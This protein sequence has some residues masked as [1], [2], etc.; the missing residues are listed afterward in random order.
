MARRGRGLARRRRRAG[1]R[2]ARSRRP[3]RDSA[4]S[5]AA[6]RPSRSPARARA[7]A[8]RR[9]ARE[10]P[11]AV[12]P[13]VAVAFVAQSQGTTS[14]PVAK[15]GTGPLGAR[16]R[17]RR[18]APAPGDDDRPARRRRPGRGAAKGPSP[19]KGVETRVAGA[20]GARRP[21]RHAGRAGGRRRRAPRSIANASD[22]VLGG[23]SRP[24]VAAPAAAV[25]RGTTACAA[26]APSRLLQVSCCRARASRAY[27]AARVR[28]ARVRA[29]SSPLDL[30][31][32]G[33]RSRTR[34][35]TSCSCWATA[36][37]TLA[38]AAHMDEIGLR[39]HEDLRRRPT[40]VQA[41]RRADRVA[42]S[43]RRSSSWSRA[44]GTVL[45]GIVPGAEG[46]AQA[47]APDQEPVVRGGR[48]RAQRGRGRGAGGRGRRRRH[49]ARR[50]RTPL[51]RTAR[52]A[53]ATTIASAAR[54]SCSRCARLGPGC[55]REAA[56]R[57]PPRA[58]LR[59]QPRARRSASGRRGPSPATLRPVPEVV[60]AVDTFVTSDS[61]RMEDPRY[62]FAR[63]GRRPVLR[64]L[65]NSS[66]TPRPAL[67]RVRAVRGAG[68][69][70]AADR[71]SMGGATT[72]AASSRGRDR[73]PAGLAAA[74]QPLA[75]RD[76]GPARPRAAG[77]AHRGGSRRSS[78]RRS[79]AQ[80]R[81][82]NLRRPAPRDRRARKNPPRV[83]EAEGARDEVAG[84][85]LHLGCCA[86]LHLVVEAAARGLDAGSSAS[87][88]RAAAAAAGSSRWP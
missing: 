18:A 46:R 66:I 77:V 17:G 14:V 19:I 47:P 65:D 49:R 21:C 45:P 16:R 12:R 31:R 81:E 30:A 58:W 51:A 79:R 62:A 20:R 43:A 54:R 6:A 69:R 70:R 67:D 34:P 72:A 9:A 75:R 8:A 3:A 74:L 61:S 80:A 40:G 41:R 7:A 28:R 10:R 57:R 26:A 83:G 82:R 59:L 71:A 64:A 36:T 39:G 50:S 11:A 76:A 29:G 86:A 35:A 55:R 13:S 25:A 15:G 4:C 23:A 53:A 68:R 1:H 42:C 27:A 5:P 32:T 38:F 48:R 2:A 33:R 56:R 22:A 37:R 60:F 52:P 63:A 85:G 44:S 88:R 73:L 84:E 78:E 24:P 87:M